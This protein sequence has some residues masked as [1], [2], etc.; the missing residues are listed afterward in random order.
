[1]LCFTGS[2]IYISFC[3]FWDL[4]PSVTLLTLSPA[5]SNLLSSLAPSLLHK[6]MCKSPESL[7]HASAQPCFLYPSPVFLTLLHLL[8]FRWPPTVPIKPCSVKAS[9]DLVTDFNRNHLVS[10]STSFIHSINFVESLLC[11]RHNSRY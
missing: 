3:I 8:T 10:S 6:N 11:D 7:N 4:G 2:A 1:M 9:N 5:S